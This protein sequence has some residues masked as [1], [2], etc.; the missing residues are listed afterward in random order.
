MY[1]DFYGLRERPFS[2]TPDPKFLFL[3]PGHR[4]ALAQLIYGV[5]EGKGFIVLTGEVGTGK[6]TLLRTFMERIGPSTHVAFIFDSTMPYDGLVEY[7]LE[8][9]GIPSAG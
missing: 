9:F 3:T 4:E 7:M 1:L 6:T 2:E 8:D 5:Q